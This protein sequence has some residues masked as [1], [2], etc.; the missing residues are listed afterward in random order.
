MI[1]AGHVL[2]NVNVLV[3]CELAGEKSTSR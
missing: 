3:W 2:K 1:E